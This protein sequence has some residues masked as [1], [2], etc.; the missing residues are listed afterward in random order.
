MEAVPANLVGLG[1][2]PIDRIGG[3]RR[4]QC[5]KEG[6]VEHC[7]VRNVWQFFARHLD[8]DHVGRIVQR[9]KVR[10]IR[11]GFHDA[12]VDESRRIE[13]VTTVHDSVTDCDDSG[14]TQRPPDLGDDVEHHL[15]TCAVIGDRKAPVFDSGAVVVDDVAVGLT[16]AL[17]ETV[18]HRFR[19]IRMHELKFDG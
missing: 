2:I 7:D 4:G 17:D 9:R 19:R 14:L 6:G 10:Q 5:V 16:D 8:T 3:R 1:H 12:V 15:Q 11:D 18:R 13:D